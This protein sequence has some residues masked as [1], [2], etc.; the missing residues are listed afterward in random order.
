MDAQYKV[1]RDEAVG[2]QFK[3]RDS[4]EDKGLPL[5]R[6]LESEIQRVVDDLQTERNPRTIDGQV[7]QVQ[8]LLKDTQ[9]ADPLVMSAQDMN[10]LHERFEAFRMSLRKFDNF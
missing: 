2:L 5:A 4:L 10:F 7:K 9:H 3:F 6:S 1:A 8:R